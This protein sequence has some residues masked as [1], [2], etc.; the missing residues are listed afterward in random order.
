MHDTAM[1]Q[2]VVQRIVLRHAIVPEGEAVRLP[3]PAHDI[4]GPLDVFVQQ[5][6]KLVAFGRR[7]SE[8]SRGEAG[9][10]EQAVATGFGM[11]AHHRMSHWRMLAPRPG[12]AFDSHIVRR[13]VIGRKGARE[14]VL[15]LEGR[16][17]I[18]ERLGQSIIGRM[19]DHTVSPPSGGI[20]LA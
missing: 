12:V 1:G 19:L 15:R 8:N 4:F 14:I 10:D 11:R 5:L 13:H 18:A 7:N 3:V 9:I 16:E 20:C 6:E 2:V 17:K